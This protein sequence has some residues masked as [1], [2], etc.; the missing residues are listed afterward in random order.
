MEITPKTLRENKRIRDMLSAFDFEVVDEPFDHTWFKT[1]NLQ[2]FE[3]VARRASGCL[4]S[5]FGPR[6]S[7]LLVTSE[8][9]AGVIAATL[10]ECLDL[11]VQYPYWQD[12]VTRS[13]GDLREL[14]NI[15]R[16]ERE[17]FEEEAL[18]DNPEIE[19]YRPLLID[20]L[21]LITP[22]DP[23][24]RLHFA[25]CRLGADVTLYHN[26]GYALSPLF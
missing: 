24:G 15:V 5:V 14:R 19:E 4:F 13:G 26:D 7:I 10:R 2:P 23:A 18:E 25:I 3:I 20:E 11:V 22:A 8:G 21:G 6:Q 9:G 16:D 12:M 17:L 1:D